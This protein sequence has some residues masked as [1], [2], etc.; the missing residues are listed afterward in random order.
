M[1]VCIYFDDYFTC[2]FRG[3]LYMPI[4]RTL[5]AMYTEHNTLARYPWYAMAC[6][7]WEGEG[8]D[9]RS[10]A[11]SIWPG[12]DPTQPFSTPVQC[13]LL[14]RRLQV[15]VLSDLLMTRWQTLQD[16]I[17]C[18]LVQL[19]QSPVLLPAALAT[20][21][22]LAGTTTPKRLTWTVPD[23]PSTSSR[24]CFHAIG[25]LKE[26]QHTFTRLALDDTG[27]EK[28]AKSVHPLTSPTV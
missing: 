9:C 11:C 5:P 7:L 24:G 26:G 10:V 14:Y 1:W 6:V 4:S 19:L 8:N 25:V 3:L 2:P 17:Q 16:P 18:G 15:N 23:G 21:L 28:E 27:V 20:P 12:I 13:C 22:A